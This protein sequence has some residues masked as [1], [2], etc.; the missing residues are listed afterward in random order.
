V[1]LSWLLSPQHPGH[2]FVREGSMH[3]L[4]IHDIELLSQFIVRQELELLGEDPAAFGI[5]PELS[6]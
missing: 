2:H 1:D 4:E 3:M 5:D 6:Y